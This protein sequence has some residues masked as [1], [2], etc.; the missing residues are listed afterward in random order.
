MV[1]SATGTDACTC[2]T[3][4]ARPTAGQAAPRQHSEARNTRFRSPCSSRTHSLGTQ[5]RDELNMELRTLDDAYLSATEPA[6]REP[7]LRS[8]GFLWVAVPA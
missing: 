8:G 6:Q 4:C 2:Q 7:G 5:G 1:C 3:R